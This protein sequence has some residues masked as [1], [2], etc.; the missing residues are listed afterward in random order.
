MIIP[1]P[2]KIVFLPFLRPRQFLGGLPVYAP[3]IEPVRIEPVRP[4]PERPKPTP[5]DDH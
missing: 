4:E 3:R 1:K 5:A 2:R